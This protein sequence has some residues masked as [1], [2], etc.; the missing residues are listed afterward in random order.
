MTAT[1]S[2]PSTL[3]ARIVSEQQHWQPVLRANDIRAD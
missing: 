2:L 3:A 1:S